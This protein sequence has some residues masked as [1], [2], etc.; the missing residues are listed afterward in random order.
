MAEK[1]EVISNLGQ[2]QGRRD[3]E[4]NA[5][6]EPTMP[7]S[8]TKVT[9]DTRRLQVPFMWNKKVVEKWKRKQNRRL[10]AQRSE[11]ELETQ[12]SEEEP[13]MSSD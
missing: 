13:D 10:C 4:D 1:I 6:V 7:E 5:L 12:S 3:A 8:H 9:P 2:V 11:A